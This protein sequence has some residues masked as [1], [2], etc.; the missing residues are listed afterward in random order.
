LLLLSVPLAVLP[1][2]RIG[3]ESPF[4]L[5]TA[6]VALTVVTLIRALELPDEAISSAS[7]REIFSIMAD[8]FRPVPAAAAPAF[9]TKKTSF[10]GGYLNMLVPT[11]EVVHADD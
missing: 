7:A 5:I 8:L 2:G 1:R 9:C 3:V 10:V 4:G 11:D 6:G